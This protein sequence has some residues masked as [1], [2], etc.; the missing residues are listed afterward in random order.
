M[1]TCRVA[2][3]R[4]RSHL[5]VNSLTG[6]L[7][8]EIGALETLNFEGCELGYPGYDKPQNQF[9]LP[10]PLEV[11]ARC[12]TDGGTAVPHK[13]EGHLTCG[14]CMR[15]RC[16]SWGLNKCATRKGYKDPEAG[17]REL[18]MCGC[19]GEQC[20]INH[21]N[22]ALHARREAEAAAHARHAESPLVL[23]VGALVAGVGLTAVVAARL[24]RRRS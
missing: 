20:A 13:Q 9:K 11:Q 1:R 4:A 23:L 14:M 22:C 17:D 6:Q 12:V 8:T 10:I 3:S 7:P 5:S 15:H 2:T 18:C 21:A 19:C 16:T 24:T